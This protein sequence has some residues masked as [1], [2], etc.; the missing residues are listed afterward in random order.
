MADSHPLFGTIK[1]LTRCVT[2][3]YYATGP[4]RRHRTLDHV[5]KLIRIDEGDQY[6]HTVWPTEAPFPYTSFQWGQGEWAEYE[7]RYRPEGYAGGQY[8]KVAW[9][10]WLNKHPDPKEWTYKDS[11]V[12]ELMKKIRQAGKG[13]SPVY[14]N[15]LAPRKGHRPLLSLH[16]LDLRSLG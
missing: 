4:R 9:S 5:R 14:W 6:L 8:D 1:F 10:V 13:D 7:E 2:E 12:Y 11:Y 15:S 3:G 16:T